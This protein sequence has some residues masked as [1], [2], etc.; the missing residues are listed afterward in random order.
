MAN[1]TL[2]QPMSTIT[3]T[4]LNAISTHLEALISSLAHSTTYATAPASATS[5]LLA[6]DNLTTAL[7]AL[8]QHQQ[9]YAH[10]LHLREEATHLSDEIKS[11][12]RRAVALREEAGRVHPSILDDDYDSSDEDDEQSEVDY[13]TLLDFAARIGKHNS[14]A[15]REAEGQW[16]RRKIEAMKKGEERKAHSTGAADIAR[17]IANANAPKAEVRVGEGVAAAE[18]Q[19][20]KEAETDE[21]ESQALHLEAALATRRAQ[22]GLGFPDPALLRMGE[23][24]RLQKIREDAMAGARGGG[25]VLVGEAAVEREV[26]RL[27]RETEHVALPEKKEADDTEMEQEERRG[28]AARNTGPSASA[29]PRQA[30]SQAH[31]PPA[32]VQKRKKI[33]LDLGGD[34]DDEDEND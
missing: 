12:I 16:E 26:E 4:P 21:L 10:I 15:M 6:D 33:N 17:A 18:S 8:K 19:V 1:D 11:L 22:Q 34:D 2:T 23:L 32:P 14:L 7:N 20:A 3:T 24:G 31:R 9:N 5:L 29:V 28:E 27:V 30:S 25:D 13:Q